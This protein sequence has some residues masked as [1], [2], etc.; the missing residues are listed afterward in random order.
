MRTPSRILAKNKR[1]R[2]R[3]RLRLAA[4]YRLKKNYCTA[5]QFETA[6][7]E[8]NNRCG[9]CQ[10]MFDDSLTPCADHNHETKTFRGALCHACNLGLGKFND[11]LSR[12][13]AAI[14]WL[15]R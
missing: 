15:R 1:Y 2:Q 13:E 14:A 10:R 4:Y 12:L 5:E 7:H 6:L 9:I 3:N 11:S 8:Q